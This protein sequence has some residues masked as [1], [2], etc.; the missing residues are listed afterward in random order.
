MRYLIVLTFLIFTGCSSPTG[1]T[2]SSSAGKS[3]LSVSLDSPSST[4][5]PLAASPTVYGGTTLQVGASGGTPPYQYSVSGCDSTIDPNSGLFTAAG[6]VSSCQITVTDSAGNTATISVSVAS[7][8]TTGTGTTNTTTTSLPGPAITVTTGSTLTVTP[9]GGTTPYS[10]SLTG[11][12]STIDPNTGAFTAASDAPETCTILITDAVGDSVTETIDVE[13]GTASGT[14]TEPLK[15]HH[16]FRAVPVSTTSQF[17]ANGGTPPYTFQVVGC[18][19]T[20]DAQSGLFTAAADPSFCLVDVTD[21]A[22]STAQAFVDVVQSNP[23]WSL[24]GNQWAG[25]YSQN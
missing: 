7:Q 16:Q 14:S 6:D 10:F 3:P 8:T 19:S 24:W 15:I 20:I 12:D 2:S 1:S 17:N 5:Q 21:S 4:T 23:W 18:D 9:S 25:A 22:G 13:A 11:C